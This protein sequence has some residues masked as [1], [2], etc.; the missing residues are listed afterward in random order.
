M[1][2]S[3][4]TGGFSPGTW[5]SATDGSREIIDGTGIW[6]DEQARESGQ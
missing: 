6:P 2:I 4:S 5:L 3:R 1:T